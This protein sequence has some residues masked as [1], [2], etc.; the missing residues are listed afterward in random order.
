V[1]AVTPQVA[2]QALGALRFRPDHRVVSLV[3]TFSL[4]RLRPLVEPAEAI[5]RMV[6]LPA[7]AERMGAVLLHPPS[8]DIAALLKGLGLLVELETEA[9][10]DAFLAVTALMG[11]YFGL[12]DE[13]SR[14]LSRHVSDDAEAQP[15]VG[16]VFHA[17]GSSAEK[18]AAVGF[19]RL[20][21]DHSTPQ[22]LNEQ[23]WRELKAAGWTGLVSETLDLI[24]ARIEGRA[25]FADRLP[26]NRAKPS[27]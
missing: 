2:E 14:W 18:H 19:D 7:V 15:F 12:L 25:N 9:D 22:G 3:A 21:V 13:V 27:S 1:L 10:M 4:A 20:A 17:L 16:A 26:R 24:H 11:G 6:P 8:A 23:A 5:V